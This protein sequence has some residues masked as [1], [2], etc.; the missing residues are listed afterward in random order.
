MDWCNY[1]KLALNCDKTKLMIFTNKKL[2][3]PPL[4]VNDHEISKV[5][6]YK[7]LGLHIDN[8][9][10]YKSHIKKLTSKLSSLCYA[11][12]KIHKLK[13]G[14]AMVQKLFIME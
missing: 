12:T 14:D 9:L 5:D 4:I 8:K 6:S 11:T 7:Y 1:N 3:I 2:Y 10:K 13:Q